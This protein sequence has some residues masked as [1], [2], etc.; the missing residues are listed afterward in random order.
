MKLEKAKEHYLARLR[1]EW[2]ED[3]QVNDSIAGADMEVSAPEST[4]NVAKSEHIQIFFP[5][6]GEVV[7]CFASHRVFI[8][9]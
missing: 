6:L 4:E 5:S 7:L 8:L 9:R 2:E 1:R 3:A